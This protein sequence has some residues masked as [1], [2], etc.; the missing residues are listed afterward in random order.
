MNFDINSSWFAV[1]GLGF[2]RTKEI[3]ENYINLEEINDPQRQ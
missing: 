2:H 1:F 3:I